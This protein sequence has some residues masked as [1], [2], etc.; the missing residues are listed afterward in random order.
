MRA[1]PIF[2]ATVLA[3]ALAVA[4]GTATA[5]AAPSTGYRDIQDFASAGFWRTI[6]DCLAANPTVVFT[7]GDDLQNPIGSGAPGS[8]SD[9]VVE[10]RLFD[11]CAESPVAFLSGFTPGVDPDITRLESAAVRQVTV[12]LVDE[13]G[14]ISVDAVVDLTWAGNDD[15]TVRVDH[16]NSGYFRQERFVTAQVAGTLV[17]LDSPVW[18]GGMNFTAADAY[19]ATIGTAS[20]ISLP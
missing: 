18:A 15:R 17:F 6:A 19:G 12:R 14:D 20:E 9:V 3:L 16:G 13:S 8:W 4:L 10:L 5:A 11:T 7:A 1:S 2:R